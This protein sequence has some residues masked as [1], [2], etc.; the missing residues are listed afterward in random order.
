MAQPIFP[1]SR[2]LR[3]DIRSSECD[4]SEPREQA[5]GF[6]EFRKFLKNPRRELMPSPANTG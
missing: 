3:G 4:L 6:F 5:S 1:A 2:K